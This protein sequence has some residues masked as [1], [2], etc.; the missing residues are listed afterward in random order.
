MATTI[1]N[2]TRWRRFA[3]DQSLEQGSPFVADLLE[4]IVDT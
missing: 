4:V 3:A 2:W 1:V